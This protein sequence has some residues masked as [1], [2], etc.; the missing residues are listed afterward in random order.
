VENDAYATVSEG[1]LTFRSWPAH[2]PPCDC[3]ACP[4]GDRLC[5]GW[6][7]RR[8]A[9]DDLPSNFCTL[10]AAVVKASMSRNTVN[11]LMAAAYLALAAGTFVCMGF[12]MWVIGIVIRPVMDWLSLHWWFWALLLGWLAISIIN[13][14]RK[15]RRAKKG[16]ILPPLLSDR[17]GASSDQSASEQFGPVGR[18]LRSR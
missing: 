11:W 1:L 17:R 16:E 12:T 10:F 4:S 9:F 15:L 14:Q 5:A 7:L 2:G 6:V 18:S 13:G 8:T 3:S